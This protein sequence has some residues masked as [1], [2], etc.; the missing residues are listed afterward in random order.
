M[1]LIYCDAMNYPDAIKTL[2]NDLA[3]APKTA[4]TALAERLVKGAKIDDLAKTHQLP[5]NFRMDHIARNSSAPVDYTHDSILGAPYADDETQPLEAGEKWHHGRRYSNT[6]LKYAFDKVGRPLNPYMNTGLAGRGVLGQF[7]PNHAVDNGILLIK[8]DSQGA[9]KLYAIGILRKFD[10]DAPALSGGFA[11]YRRDAKGAYI[12]D[13]DAVVETQVEELFE[14]MIS[15]SIPL[16]AE[17]QQKLSQAIQDEY[18]RRMQGRNGLELS[19]QLKE[20]IAAQVETGLKMQQVENDDPNFLKRLHDV[21]AKGHECFAGPVLNDNRNTNNAWIETQ[22]SWFVMDDDKWAYIKGTNPV[23]DYQFSAG[24]DASGV[25]EHEISPTLI[26]DAFAS[27]GALFSFMCASY[28]LKTQDNGDHLDASII[29]QLE[30]VADYLTNQVKAPK[31]NA[32]F[33]P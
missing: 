14:E 5:V 25:V 4:A 11:K 32:V 15:G 1:K 9:K 7:G 28:L 33:K 31:N 24:D 16:N 20:E 10:N 3:G 19:D 6:G 23:Y 29:K 12:F 2:E 30:N 13:R 18:D 27:H 8:E 22:L 17:N 26:K 21:V